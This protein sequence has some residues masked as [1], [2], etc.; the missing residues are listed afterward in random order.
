MSA[1][2]PRRCSD[3]QR[4]QTH[5]IAHKRPE[6]ISGQWDRWRAE[7]HAYFL[8]RLRDTP[9]GEGNML[10]RTVVLWGSAHP[11]GSHETRKTTRSTWP[12]AARPG[13]QARQPPRLRGRQEGAA[14]PTSS[15][16]CSTAIGVPTEKFADSDRR[17]DRSP[18]LIDAVLVRHRPAPPEVRRRRR[19]PTPASSS[20][21]TASTASPPPK[22]PKPSKAR[23]ESSTPPCNPAKSATP[24][25]PS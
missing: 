15:S 2:T 17:D 23:P 9:E 18:G 14:W 22:P 4:R 7:Q 24:P 13:L 10:D 19:L 8:E 6:D 20:S 12:G 5:D 11:H 1:S 21:A 16:R 25:P 3:Y